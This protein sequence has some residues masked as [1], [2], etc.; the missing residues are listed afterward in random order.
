MRARAR[1]YPRRQGG[2]QSSNTH[3]ST[4]D[5][6]RSD[7]CRGLSASTRRTGARL[8]CARTRDAA[9]GGR[10]TGH[11][12]R[13]PGQPVLARGLPGHLRGLRRH[14]CDRR[15]PGRRHGAAGGHRAAHCAWARHRACHPAARHGPH[16]GVV[17]RQPRGADPLLVP[18]RD[19]QPLASAC[20]SGLHPRA[21]GGGS[22]LGGAH[23]PVGDACD[24]AAPSVPGERRAGRAR[25]R[26]FPAGGDHR[27]RARPAT[28]A[29]P[30][31]RDRSGSSASARSSSPCAGRSP[32]R[33]DS[34]GASCCWPPSSR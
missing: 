6:G 17:R 14:R 25:H 8:R 2:T 15:R 12:G 1:Y 11:R 30:G 13:V 5:P 20:D 27:R 33:G 22:G 26:G 18:I 32:A 4:P 21:V 31:P 3:A 19:Q 34:A 29:P 24:V 9:G 16:P 7:E 23:T 10:R 28:T